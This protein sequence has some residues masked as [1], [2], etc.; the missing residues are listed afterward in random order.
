MFHQ[1]A[2][3][4][5]ALFVA[6]K[7][8][9]A[10]K[11]EKGSMNIGGIMMLGISMVF[12]SIGFIFLPITTSAT[13]TLLDYS[14][15]SYT[16]ITDATYTGYTS[17]LGVTPLLILVGF[18]TAAV[19]TGMLGIKIIKGAK[20]ANMNPGSLM[21]LGLSIVFIGIGL[22]MQPVVL[23]AV[24]SNVAH[25]ASYTDT[26]EVVTSVGSTSNT[27]DLTY[28]LYNDSL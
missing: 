25:E 1:I 20:S 28:R 15:S 2:Q 8:L 7:A 27:T 17:V 10:V 9:I 12:L 24:S 11:R 18:L 21:M 23:D 4:I 16:L 6:E 5:K 3:S 26:K 13:Q 19:I 14:Y 22:I